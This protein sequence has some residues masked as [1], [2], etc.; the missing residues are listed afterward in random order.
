MTGRKSVPFLSH[1]DETALDPELD[2]HLVVEA[3][4][5]CFQISLRKELLGQ[6]RTKIRVVE[7]GGA[8]GDV[9]GVVVTRGWERLRVER[10]P[11]VAAQIGELRTRDDERIEAVLGEQRADRMDART[12]IGP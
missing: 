11:T 4:P 2:Q 5:R 10:V 9:E 1:G 8:A 12:S 7:L 6:D 3:G